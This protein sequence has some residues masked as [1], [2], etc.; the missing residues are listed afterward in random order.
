MYGGARLFKKVHEGFWGY[1]AG[2]IG[3]AVGAVAG[4]AATVFALLQLNK[5][6]SPEDKHQFE[7]TVRERA[8]EVQANADRWR[9]S[10]R[11]EDYRDAVS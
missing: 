9:E 10:G 8:I 3:A 7:E 6:M 11:R 4:L 1:L 2:A 5:T